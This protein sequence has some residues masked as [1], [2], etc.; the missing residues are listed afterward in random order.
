V[1]NWQRPSRCDSNSCVEVNTVLLIDDSTVV[2]VR[3]STDPRTKVVFTG[4]EWT[5]FLNAVKKGEFD[6]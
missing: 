3:T 6:Q 5:D 4:E 1:S 2:M